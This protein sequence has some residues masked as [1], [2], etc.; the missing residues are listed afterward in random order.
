MY[1]SFPDLLLTLHWSLPNFLL[2][3]HWS[4]PNFLFTLFWCLPHLSF[5]LQ[6]LFI[7]S[8]FPVDNTVHVI[9]V[10]LQCSL[11]FVST[12]LLTLTN[13][14]NKIINMWEIFWWAEKIKMLVRNHTSLRNIFYL[15]CKII[16][17]HKLNLA[18]VWPCL[19]WNQQT[20]EI[21]QLITRYTFIH[22]NLFYQ[23]NVNFNILET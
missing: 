12:S 3:L 18:K 17:K 13:S 2:N 20:N 6:F 8:I 23:V 19:Q 9:S 22:P 4:L 7:K 10:L 11:L 21:Q 16:I 15:V 1:W 5:Q 14:R